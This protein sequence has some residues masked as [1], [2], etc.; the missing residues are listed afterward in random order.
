MTANVRKRIR[1]RPGNGSPAPVVNGIAS[2][3]ASETPPR[4]P[5]QEISASVLTEGMGSRSRIRRTN[6]KGSHAAG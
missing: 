2:A 3:A 5:D 1:S 4:I 6:R